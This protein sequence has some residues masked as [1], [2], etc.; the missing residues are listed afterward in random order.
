MSVT[1]AS[2]PQQLAAET[3]VPLVAAVTAYPLSTPSFTQQV[4]T[5]LQMDG[6]VTTTTTVI[7]LLSAAVLMLIVII[8]VQ[9]VVHRKSKRC[10]RFGLAAVA[11]NV[12]ACP[13]EGAT[14]PYPQNIVVA[15]GHTVA[16]SVDASGKQAA[17]GGTAGRGGTLPVL[18]ANAEDAGYGS[19][20]SLPP[21]A[22]SC[23]CHTRGNGDGGSSGEASVHASPCASSRRRLTIS[24]QRSV[25]SD[26]G[27]VIASRGEQG[28]QRA[29]TASGGGGSINL[30]RAASVNLARGWSSG[31]LPVGSTMRTPLAAS[32]AIWCGGATSACRHAAGADAVRCEDY[33]PG[34]VQTHRSLFAALRA[35]RNS[36]IGQVD[37][38]IES[39]APPLLV[40]AAKDAA[41]VAATPTPSSDA[42]RLGSSGE[43]GIDIEKVK[44][45]DEV[46][47]ILSRQ[48]MSDRYLSS[49]AAAQQQAA[50]Q[51]IYVFPVPDEPS[52]DGE[53][54]AAPLPAAALQGRYVVLGAGLP[55]ESH[56]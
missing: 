52:I 17:R 20:Y 41:A 23:H 19:V 35:R 26:G 39:D 30:A 33:G 6:S 11:R 9:A 44:S 28:A 43:P 53:G 7:G 36:K 31:T 50:S 13:N 10:C 40:A 14:T 5:G 47:L 12:D 4:D 55:G 27:G 45:M 49:S 1:T 51:D 21:K 29:A 34:G 32:A 24:H 8:V 16:T 38:A 22:C 54:S 56:L 25:L 46:L 15:G 37:V 2:Q 3:S 18:A 42:G 48:D